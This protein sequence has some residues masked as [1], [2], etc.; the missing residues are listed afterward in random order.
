MEPISIIGAVGAMANIID[1]VTRSIKHMSELRDRWKNADLTLLSLA[2]QLTAL[3]GALS[4][5]QAWMETGL[6]G[7]PHH[8]LIMD[9]DVSIKCCQLLAGKIEALVEDLSHDFDKPREFSSIV[10]QVFNVKSIDDVQKLLD[11]QTNA[12]T[13]LLTACNW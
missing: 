12:L 7:D 3:R 8:Q 11:Q 10:K 13:L 9:L 6:D 5:I 2:S 4:K 1:V